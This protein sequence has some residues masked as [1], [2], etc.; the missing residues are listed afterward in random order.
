MKT[1]FNF[2][3]SGCLLLFLIFC[4]SIFPL[5]INAASFPVGLEVSKIDNIPD[6]S[7]TGVVDDLQCGFATIEFPDGSVINNNNGYISKPN[8]E[9]GT[10]ITATATPNAGYRFLRWHV[11]RPSDLLAGVDVY[12]NTITFETPGGNGRTDIYPV[13]YAPS[14]ITISKVA[15][16]NSPNPGDTVEY[17]ITVKNGGTTSLYGVVVNDVFPENWQRTIISPNAYSFNGDKIILGDMQPSD[18]IIIKYTIAIPSTAQLGAYKNTAEVQAKYSDGTL[19]PVSHF[20][21]MSKLQD[22]E[23]I[24]VVTPVKP[25][26]NEPTSSSNGTTDTTP[27]YDYTISYNTTS[28]PEAVPSKEKKVKG[29]IIKAKDLTICV[30]DPFK[31][32]RG[33][34]AFENM[35]KGKEITNKVTTTGKINTGVEGT[36]EITYRVKDQYGNRAEQ[37]RTVTIKQC[38]GLLEP[39]EIEKIDIHTKP[40]SFIEPKEKPV[41]CPTA[42]PVCCPCCGRV[43]GWIRSY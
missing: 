38:E 42:I 3:S 34:T 26:D 14:N 35:G 22:D 39:E 6:N 15:N 29:P 41:C 28:E 17:T 21:N 20:D 16:N 11:R 18:V 9:E 37:I 33:V 19:I 7:L 8:V 13:F 5:I 30:N 2:K 23:I 40:T 4:F 32:M 43:I 24:N 1:I 31:I 27:S 25:N 12:Q 36:Y 10:T